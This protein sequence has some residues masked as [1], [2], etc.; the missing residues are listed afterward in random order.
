[1]ST[2]RWTACRCLRATLLLPIHQMP[3]SCALLPRPCYCYTAQQ[4]DSRTPRFSG[5]LN[6][7]ILRFSDPFLKRRNLIGRDDDVQNVPLMS[8][9]IWTY[10]GHTY[11]GHTYDYL[12]L[13]GTP[14]YSCLYAYGHMVGIQMV[15]IHTT[16]W[17][18]LMLPDA[19][20]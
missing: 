11:G 7:C 1:M 14:W 10:G 5:S 3:K 16:T 13:S 19:P 15:D 17:C 12:V 6:S 8:L 2:L 4:R 9:C 18:S 20:W